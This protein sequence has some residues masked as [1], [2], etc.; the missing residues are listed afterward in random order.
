MIFVGRIIFKCFQQHLVDIGDSQ[1][2]EQSLSTFSSHMN[3]IID[4]LDKSDYSSLILLDELGSGIDPVEGSA[5]AVSIIEKIVRNGAKLITTTH[6]QELK[7]FALNTPNVQNASCEFDVKTLM[8]TYRL[9]IG[10]PTF[11]R[12]CNFFKTWTF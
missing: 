8:P 11:K 3:R 6:Y 12:I 9:I 4:I 1:S 10:S 7:M 2:I 5:L